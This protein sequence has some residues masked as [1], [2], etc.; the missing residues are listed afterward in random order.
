MANNVTVTLKQVREFVLGELRKKGDAGATPLELGVALENWLKERGVDISN[1]I[2]TIIEAI[3][4]D[5]VFRKLTRFDGER[6]R[7]VEYKEKEMERR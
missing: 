3:I 5:P 1:G 4:W 2:G 6:T 7:L